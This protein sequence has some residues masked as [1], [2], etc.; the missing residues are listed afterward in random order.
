MPK[1]DEDDRERPEICGTLP[2]DVFPKPTI[3]TAVVIVSLLPT[4]NLLT[5]LV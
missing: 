1:D 5:E 4:P 3:L 2:V